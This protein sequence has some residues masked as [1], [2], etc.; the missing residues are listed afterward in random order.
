MFRLERVARFACMLQECPL[1]AQDAASCCHL[2][3]TFSC[4]GCTRQTRL[5]KNQY[6]FAAA[7]AALQVCGAKISARYIKP[8][9]RQ[10]SDPDPEASPTAAPVGQGERSGPGG[11]ACEALAGSSNALTGSRDRTDE[12]PAKRPCTGPPAA[13]TTIA[14]GPA[15]LPDPISNPVH[16]FD[17][18]SNERLVANGTSGS[19][20]GLGTANGHMAPPA[21]HLEDEG[22]KRASNPTLSGHAGPV[23]GSER[24][25]ALATN[26]SAGFSGADA[27]ERTNGTANGVGAEAAGKSQGSGLRLGQGA[28]A[29]AGAHTGA[30]ARQP[31]AG[32]GLGDGS[33]AVKAGGGGDPEP[34]S[35]LLYDAARA[36]RCLWRGFGVSVVSLCPHLRTRLK[37]LLWST[38]RT[39]ACIFTWQRFLDK[40][41]AGFVFIVVCDW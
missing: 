25:A 16:H 11:S 6:D 38:R 19:G 31:P 20:S 13:A 27:P 8:A 1:T 4:A 14:G 10:K 36:A 28:A 34:A 2:V 15:G 7:D 12:R 39:P 9:A 32:G 26:P 37:T 3:A 17:V 18:H 41:D 23:G 29:A 24:A 21:S 40:T 33:G 30:C 22:G 5:R 35:A